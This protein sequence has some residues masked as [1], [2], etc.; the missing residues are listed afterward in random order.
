VN[1]TKFSGYCDKTGG[2]RKKKKKGTLLHK[3][4]IMGSVITQQFQHHNLS[5]AC[6]LI[7]SLCER[8][9]YREEYNKLQWIQLL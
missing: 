7:F 9:F 5:L 2:E 3:I 8:V 4:D 1:K 6:S